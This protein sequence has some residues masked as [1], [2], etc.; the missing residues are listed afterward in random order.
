MT[1]ETKIGLLIG[2]GFIVVFA[3]LLSH[4]GQVRPVGDNMDQ[5]FARRGGEPDG[6]VGPVGSET[7][8]PEVRMSS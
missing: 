2:L 4:T 3:L 1:R 6:A 8:F 5:V 7:V